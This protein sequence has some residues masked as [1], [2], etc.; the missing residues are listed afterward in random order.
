MNTRRY[1][2]PLPLMRERKSK[3]R[4]E[5]SGGK[6]ARETEETCELRTWLFDNLDRDDARAALDAPLSQVGFSRLGQS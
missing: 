5:N 3:R 6:T 4:T 2:A 1:G